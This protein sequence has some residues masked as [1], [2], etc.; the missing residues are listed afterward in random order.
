MS[1][2][3]PHPKL[4]LVCAICHRPMQKAAA[5]QGGYPVGPVCARAAGLLPPVQR[6]LLAGAAAPVQ[7]DTL[8]IDMFGQA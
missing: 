5:L 2:A 8:T 7:R 4:R 1:S 3:R 6:D